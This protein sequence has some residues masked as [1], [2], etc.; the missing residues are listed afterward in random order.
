[1]N[2]SGHQQTVCIPHQRTRL[3]LYRR[4]GATDKKGE[5]LSVLAEEEFEELMILAE[6]KLPGFRAALDHAMFM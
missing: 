3:L 2:C 6:T 5:T 1:M 4:A